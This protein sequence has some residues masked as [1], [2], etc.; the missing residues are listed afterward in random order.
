MARQKEFNKDQVLERAMRLFWRKGYEATSV[1]DLVNHM[2]IN[3]GSIYDT[4][5]DKQSLYYA[6]L[7][8]YQQTAGSVAMAPIAESASPLMAIRQVFANLVDE[9]VCDQL[10][11]GCFAVNAAVELAAHDSKIAEH[12]KGAICGMTVG[13]QSALAR[14]IEMGELP[15]DTDTLALARFLVNGVLGIRTLTKMDP[16]RRMLNDIVKTTLSV[17]D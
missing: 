2:G 3:R 5:G 12:S 10:R 8:H 9:A 7:E 17:L 14:A 1:N 6:A 4:F 16:D 13:F 11:G 15:T